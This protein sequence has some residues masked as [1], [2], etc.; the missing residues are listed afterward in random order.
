MPGGPA[1]GA[2]S[3][4]QFLR[5]SGER[6]LDSLPMPQSS[7]RGPIFYLSTS[8]GMRWNFADQGVQAPYAGGGF[9]SGSAGHYRFV[10]DTGG[11][12]VLMVERNARPVA[13]GSEERDQWT[14]FAEFM[15]RSRSLTVTY[16]IPRNKPFIREFKSD[17]LGRIWVDVFVA[18]ENRTNIP[19]RPPERGPLVTW[20][21]RTTFD[22]FAPSGAYLGRV[23]LPA[24]AVLMAVRDDRLWVRTKGGEGEDRITVFRVQTGGR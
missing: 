15:K 18:A 5:Y 12:K 4:Q 7:Q 2:G 19:P 9:L 17:H 20:R 21:E 3:R 6:L 24:E 8:D 23:A 11:P 16:D 13:L 22:V 10:V 14:A 1:E